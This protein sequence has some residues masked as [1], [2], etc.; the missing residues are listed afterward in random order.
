M[1][2]SLFFRQSEQFALIKGSK[3]QLKKLYCG[4]FTL[5]THLIKPNCLFFS[6][7]LHALIEEKAYL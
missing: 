7:V 3:R 4:Q 6:N 1:T 2:R 5:S